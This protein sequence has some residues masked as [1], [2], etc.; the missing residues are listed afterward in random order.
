MESAQAAFISMVMDRLQALE[1]ENVTTKA[2]VKQH[3]RMVCCTPHVV[4]GDG[5]KYF[6]DEHLIL[7]RLGHHCARSRKSGKG[8]RRENA[9]SWEATRPWFLGYEILVLYD[10]N[11]EENR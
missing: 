1:Q 5:F 4:S 7:W 11:T 2:R 6:D 10:R 8:K 3:D 9:V